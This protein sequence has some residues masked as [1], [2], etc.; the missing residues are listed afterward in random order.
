MSVLRGGLIS[1]IYQKMMTLPLGNTNESAAMSLMSSD[2]EELADSFYYMA[3]DS[4]GNVLQLILAIWLLT[5]QI[6]G[7]SVAPIIITISECLRGAIKFIMS[8]F[9]QAY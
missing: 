4:W 6:G 8:I 7:V 9:H 1:L 3:C 2:V 5:T